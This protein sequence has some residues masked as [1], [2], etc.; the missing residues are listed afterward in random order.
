MAAMDRRTLEMRP[1]GAQKAALDQ[2]NQPR[3]V[4][5]PTG[6]ECRIQRVRRPTGSDEAQPIHA[7]RGSQAGP[8]AEARKL[9]HFVRGPPQGNVRSIAYALSDGGRLR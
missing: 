4:R 1:D 5:R 8:R 6:A 2:K 7:L 9:R 3:R